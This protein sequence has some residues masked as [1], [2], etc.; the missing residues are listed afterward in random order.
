MMADFNNSQSESGTSQSESMDTYQNYTKEY[1]HGTVS[2]GKQ[3]R[4]KLNFRVD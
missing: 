1:E 4:F 2:K 3:L